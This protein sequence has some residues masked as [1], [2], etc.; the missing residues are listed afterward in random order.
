MEEKRAITKEMFVAAAPEDV[1]RALTDGAGL[2]S[3][4][5]PDA[6]VEPGVGGSI[7]ISWGEG[8]EGAAPITVWEPNRRLQWAEEHGPIRLAVDVYLE[9]ADG[10]TFVRLVHSGFGTG[11]EWDDQFHMTDGGWTYFMVNL[12]HVLERHPGAPRVMI[13]ARERVQ[14]SREDA[15]A[16]LTGPRGLAASGSLQELAV[17]DAFDVTTSAGDR[18]T[19]TVVVQRAPLHFALN[20]ENLNDALL[21]IELEPAGSGAVRP[22]LW[23]SLYG[24]P[25]SRV[26]ALRETIAQMYGSA[27]GAD[28]RAEAA[29]AV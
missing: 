27:F 13:R 4:F 11:E 1:W 29:D 20:V 25:E 19:G 8:M 12:R 6:R 15:F 7:W 26:E 9:P 3:W 16:T 21:F 28:V 17:G 23:L 2:A 5:S 24:V 10:G 14:L 22:S 18:L